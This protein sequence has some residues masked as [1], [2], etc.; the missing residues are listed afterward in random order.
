[1]PGRDFATGFLLRHKDRISK[2]LCKNIKRTRAAVRSEI[3]N[4]YFDHLQQ[5]LEGVPPC[6]VINYDET[7]LSDDAGRKKVIVKRGCKY[8]ERVM[9]TSKS[10]K[11]SL[12]FI[13]WLG[14][15]NW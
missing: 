11:Y 4:S 1:M 3:I 14:L 15:A 9:N 5:S 10:F 12:L 8:P 13:Y 7:N 6:N 2:R